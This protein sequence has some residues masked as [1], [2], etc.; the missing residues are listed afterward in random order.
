MRSNSRS[1]A[2]ASPSTKAVAFAASRSTRWYLATNWTYWNRFAAVTARSPP[3][4]TRS[5]VTTRPKASSCVT[6]NV[7]PRSPT[8]AASYNDRNFKFLCKSGST[9]ARS[10]SNAPKSKRPPR[11]T[12]AKKNRLKRGCNVTPSA[13]ALPTTRPTNL[14]RAGA[15]RAPWRL[16]AS[17]FGYICRLVSDVLNNPTSGAKTAAASSVQNSLKSPPASTPASCRPKAST[18]IIESLPRSRSRDNDAMASKPSR[19]TWPR[20]TVMSV[21][22]VAS[23]VSSVCRDDET[24]ESTSLARSRKGTHCGMY[25]S[26]G[27]CVCDDDDRASEAMAA[28]APDT[29]H[30]SA[31]ASALR[32]DRA[33]RSA[34][35]PAI[36]AS[37][38]GLPRG[39]AVA[40]SA[41]AQRCRKS[42]SLS[43]ATIVRSS[44][45]P[46]GS[47]DARSSASSTA[48][49]ACRST[50][51][52]ATVDGS[53]R[54][55]AAVA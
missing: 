4:G 18:K 1:S 48:I 47:P 45:R 29:I 32:H 52:N 31:G 17:G 35:S 12:K 2:S 23:E 34:S 3:C 42:G 19:N 22:C 39:V 28:D 11:R 27:C 50:C 53:S 44:K 40:V 33:C 26:T 46:S 16:A 41:A 49:S 54:R 25:V 24:P 8:S 37:H 7:R 38:G 51:A 21:L 5:F 9:A 6:W 43:L 10:S 15:S 55:H 30:A 20:R 14:K 36:G 13:T